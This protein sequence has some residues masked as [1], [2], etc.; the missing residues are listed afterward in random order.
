M[1]PIAS[2]RAPVGRHTPAG[3]SVGNLHGLEASSFSRNRLPE[4][5]KPHT[6]QRARVGRPDR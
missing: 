4:F 1:S 5:S 6:A 2:R 3:N